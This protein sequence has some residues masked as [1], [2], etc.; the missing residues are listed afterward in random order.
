MSKKDRREL[1]S[2]T[3]SRFIQVT[4]VLFCM[5]FIYAIFLPEYQPF[6]SLIVVMIVSTV[7]VWVT[8]FF[9]LF[10]TFMELRNSFA[11]LKG[12]PEPMNWV[13]LHSRT[14]ETI[15]TGTFLAATIFAAPLILFAFRP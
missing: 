6:I 15:V 3:V 9:F 12:K 4:V 10:L 2:D 14:T 11:K 8:G 13:L 1:I 7:I 5:S